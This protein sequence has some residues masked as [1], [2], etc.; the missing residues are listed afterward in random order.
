MLVQSKLGA[1]EQRYVDPA[2]RSPI[3]LPPREGSS[4]RTGVLGSLEL[5]T[6]LPADSTHAQIDKLDV[7]L[8]AIV[9]TEGAVMHLVELLPHEIQRG[10]A[11]QFARNFDLDLV[12]FAEIADVAD[13]VHGDRVRSDPLALDV[14]ESET[15]ELTPGRDDLVGVG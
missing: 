4:R 11:R 2:G 7:L 1:A 13:E 15:F 10:A 6:I 9:E 12:A 5:R 3:D 14:G 8:A